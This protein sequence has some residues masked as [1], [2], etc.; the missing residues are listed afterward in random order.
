MKNK[1]NVADTELLINTQYTEGLLK[2]FKPQTSL[3]VGI[4]DMLALN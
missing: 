4:K 2:C 1:H 3:E